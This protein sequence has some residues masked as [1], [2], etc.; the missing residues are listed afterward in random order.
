MNKYRLNY[1]FKFSHL[2]VAFFSSF[3]TSMW[4]TL[5]LTTFEWTF[6]SH[7]IFL[8]AQANYFLSL[9]R[10]IRGHGHGL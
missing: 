5:I 4:F 3:A 10:T 2:Q 1:I 6:I 9:A 7:T 8:G